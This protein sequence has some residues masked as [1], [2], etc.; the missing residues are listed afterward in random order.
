MKK[1]LLFL[2][3]PLLSACTRYE[4]SALSSIELQQTTEELNVAAK[5]FSKADCRYYLDRDV[6]QKGYQPVQLYIENGSGKS[7]LISL[8][9]VGLPVAS[10]EEVSR[11]MHS[12]TLARIAGYGAAALLATPLFAVPAV[13]DGYRSARSNGQLDQDFLAKGAHD[14]VIPPHSYVNMI[15]FVPKEGY[16]ERF[17]VTFLE[18]KTHRPIKILTSTR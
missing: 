7:Y 9:R 15:L 8:A 14:R 11:K 13:V 10:A 12:S 6:L 4:A 3:L 1:G 18:E 17:Q 2:L 5:A 16:R